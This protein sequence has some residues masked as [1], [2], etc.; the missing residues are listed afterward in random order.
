MCGTPYRIRGSAVTCGDAECRRLNSNRRQRKFQR[1]YTREH[2]VAYATQYR[3][4]G[5]G[6]RLNELGGSGP[7]QTPERKQER[8]QR[9]RARKLALPSETFRHEDVYRRDGWVCQLCGEPVD[10]AL[11][12]PSP[13]SASLDHAKP[14]S[15]GGHHVWDNVQ[16]AHLLCNTRKHA[17]EDPAPEG[18][19]DE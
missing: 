8:W 2:G 9:R 19:A 7:A 14:L 5:H 10:P 15:K 6:A 11:R 13:R 4:E 16:L 3:S 18:A 1:N 12:Y 17:R